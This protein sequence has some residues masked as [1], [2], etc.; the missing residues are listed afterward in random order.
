MIALLLHPLSSPCFAFPPVQHLPACAVCLP[1]TSSPLW[2]ARPAPPLAPTQYH[3]TFRRRATHQW[4]RQQ[5]LPRA[6]RL[7]RRFTLQTIRRNQI[8]CIRGKW[9]LV[10]NDG[11]RERESGR[12]GEREGHAP[13]YM[14]HIGIEVP[15][16]TNAQV[17]QP[18]PPACTNLLGDALRLALRCPGDAA[19]WTPRCS[20]P[21]LALL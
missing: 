15:P 19:W 7:K 6:F 3:A 13:L 16:Y 20:T 1:L 11:E 18:T 8:S 9:T 2:F 17:Y 12:A 10:S 21:V 14:L 5:C 4:Q